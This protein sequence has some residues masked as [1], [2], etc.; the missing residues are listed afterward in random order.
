M[1]TVADVGEP[2]RR[3]TVITLPAGNGFRNATTHPV[4]QGLRRS[5][6][7]SRAIA[8]AL[9][10]CSRIPFGAVFRAA[11]RPASTPREVGN[12]MP[13]ASILFDDDSPA[14]TPPRGRPE[15]TLRPGPGAQTDRQSSGDRCLQGLLAHLAGTHRR[16]LPDN[17]GRTTFGP[18][19]TAGAGQSRLGA[20]CHAPLP[21][22][23]SPGGSGWPP[24]S[25]LHG[26]TGPAGPVRLQWWS[27]CTSARGAVRLT[28]DQIVP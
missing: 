23:R 25:R 16:G 19:N 12:Q 11:R 10:A 2:L 4:P 21:P 27:P 14:R 24:W 26:R 22:S 17:G 13:F 7:R 15:A 18:W 3:M 6:R 8:A 9:F 20:R 1:A 28:F 5:P